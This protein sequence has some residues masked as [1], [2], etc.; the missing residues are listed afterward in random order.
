L[1]EIFSDQ[2]VTAGDFPQEKLYDVFESERGFISAVRLGI[3]FS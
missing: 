3:G 2:V 1:G